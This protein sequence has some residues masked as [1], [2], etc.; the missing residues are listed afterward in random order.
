MQIR[1]LP[2]RNGSS[3]QQERIQRERSDDEDGAESGAGVH[4]AR[5]YIPGGS[6]MMEPRWNG[7][8]RIG[9][10]AACTAS[11]WWQPP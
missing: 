10:D 2:G 3:A 11:T 9:G 4:G 8:E 7:E 6:A 5:P 1:L